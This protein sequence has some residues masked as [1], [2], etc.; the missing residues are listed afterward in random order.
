MVRKFGSM[1]RLI[2][3]DED[4]TVGLRRFLGHNL[5]FRVVGALTL[6]VTRLVYK[7]GLEEISH[8]CVL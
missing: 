7:C 5:F 4:H 8:F 3:L 2:I 6:A 1:L